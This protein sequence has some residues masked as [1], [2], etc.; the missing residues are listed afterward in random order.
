FRLPPSRVLSAQ[1]GANRNTVV[2]AYEELEAAGFVHST[3]GR[4]TFVAGG[5]EEARGHGTAPLAPAAGLPWGSLLARAVDSEPLARAERLASAVRGTAAINLNRMQPPEELIPAALFKRCIDH[6]LR[7]VGSRALAYA[8]R[9]GLPRLQGLIAED[10]R[11]QGVPA[12][13]EEV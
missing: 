12:A 10:L 8:P 13:A 6:V 1:V 11:R 5:W 4:G 2:R 7:S 9:R 3:V